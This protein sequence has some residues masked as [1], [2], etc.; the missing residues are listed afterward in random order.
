MKHLRFVIPVTAVFIVLYTGC[1]DRSA[2][3]SSTP[4]Y[5]WQDLDQLLEET[6]AVGKKRLE[7]EAARYEEGLQRDEAYRDRR[8]KLS[9]CTDK[10]YERYEKLQDR[11]EALLERQEKQADRFDALL[12]KWEEAK[13]PP[14]K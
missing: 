10:L 3:D 6:R 8:D 12:K 13:S 7:E 2:Q 11:R 1:S 5:E 9:E 14:V 4:D